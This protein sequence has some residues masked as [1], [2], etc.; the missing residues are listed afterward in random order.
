MLGDFE[1]VVTAGR[2]SLALNPAMSSTCKGL[3]SALGHLGR[4]EDAA[5]IRDQ[6]LRLEPAFTL[7]SAASRSPLRREVDRAL[8]IDGLRM[9][10]LA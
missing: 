1:T 2:R 3:L 8:Y 5:A 6:L 10:G 7:A 4:T 9:A